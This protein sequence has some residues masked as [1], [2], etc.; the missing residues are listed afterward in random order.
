MQN[1][2]ARHADDLL[3][4]AKYTNMLLLSLLFLFSFFCYITPCIKD[5]AFCRTT[6]IVSS[7]NG[8][9]FRALLTRNKITTTTQL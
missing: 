9:T 6:T 5:N 7:K 3:F 1:T 8:Q 4:P 2:S